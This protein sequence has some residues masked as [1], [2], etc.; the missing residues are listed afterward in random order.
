[1]RVFKFSEEQKTSFLS[2]YKLIFILF[3]STYKRW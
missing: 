2:L 1:V 3:S